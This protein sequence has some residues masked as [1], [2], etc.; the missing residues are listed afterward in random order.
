MAPV[1]LAISLAAGERKPRAA[2]IRWAARATMSPSSPM[3]S[4]GTRFSGA[5]MFS[6]AIILPGATKTGAVIG[7]V[8]AQDGENHAARHIQIDTIDGASLP[9]VL[10]RPRAE[11]ADWARPVEDK[12]I[13]EVS[14]MQSSSSRENKGQFRRDGCRQFLGRRTSLS[15]GLSSC[16]RLRPCT[17]TWPPRLK[18]RSDHMSD[19]SLLIAGFLIRS[20]RRPDD[21]R[22]HRQ[23]GF[24]SRPVRRGPSMPCLVLPFLHRPV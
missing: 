15:S 13:G 2:E 18:G 5:A 14:F 10:T 21:F 19:G 6:A 11:M 20:R 24:Y 16:Q 17:T 22:H 1:Q 8:R 12:P 3:R 7:A 9:N 4:S 23:A